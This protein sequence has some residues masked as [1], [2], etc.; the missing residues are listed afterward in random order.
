MIPW[1]N[2]SMATSRPTAPFKRGTKL[3]VTD[4]NING[5]KPTEAKYVRWWGAERSALVVVKYACGKG[6]EH[7]TTTH[8]DFCRPSLGLRAQRAELEPAGVHRSKSAWGITDGKKWFFYA[9]ETQAEAEAVMAKFTTPD[10]VRVNIA[11]RAPVAM[12]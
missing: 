4:P 5:G 2:G 7:E 8:V 6:G 12:A 10:H 9:Y 11:H 3:T 1:Y